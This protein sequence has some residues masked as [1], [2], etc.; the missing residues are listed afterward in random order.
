MGRLYPRLDAYQTHSN[1]AKRHRTNI[2]DRAHSAEV[3]FWEDPN[4]RLNDALIMEYTLPPEA[5]GSMLEMLTSFV[6]EVAGLGGDQKTYGVERT[7]SGRTIEGSWVRAQV[8]KHS[9]TTGSSC[10]KM[11]ALV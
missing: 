1:L 10:S 5:S 2:S 6:P 9:Q 11:A 8:V 4:T 7:H 3:A